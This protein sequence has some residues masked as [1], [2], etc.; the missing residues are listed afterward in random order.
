MRL[1][2]R[3][4]CP[5]LASA[6]ALAVAGPASAAFRS[7][8]VARSVSGSAASRTCSSGGSGW[9]LVPSAFLT[10]VAGIGVDTDAH[11]A[12]VGTVGQLEVPPVVLAARAAAQRDPVRGEVQGFGV[13]VHRDQVED[14]VG[15][16]VIDA[17]HRRQ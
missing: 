8:S 14:L 5:L 3:S 6:L 12:T 7:A 13:V 15:G 1:H 16:D 11:L 10:A 2:H 9:Y 17:R 4:V